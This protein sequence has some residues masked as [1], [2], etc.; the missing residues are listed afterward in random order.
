MRIIIDTENTNGRSF[1]R[2]YLV[3]RRFCCDT[4]ALISRT[5][6]SFMLN[7]A[8]CNIVG[9]CQSMLQVIFTLLIPTSD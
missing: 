7:M 1:D 9:F 2:T 8:D 4:P 6:N 5:G 3:L